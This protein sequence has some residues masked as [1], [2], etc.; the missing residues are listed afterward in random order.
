VHWVRETISNHG[1]DLALA[2][3]VYHDPANAVEQRDAKGLT[4]TT[5]Y[6]GL[7][8]PTKVTDALGVTS[9]ETTYDGVNQRSEKD[10]PAT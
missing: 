8:R 4:T 2:R 6:D 5:A 9:S 10:R 7:G 1:A 3:Y